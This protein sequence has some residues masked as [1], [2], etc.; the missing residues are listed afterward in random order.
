MTDEIESFELPWFNGLHQD[1]K[2]LHIITKNISVFVEVA[3]HHKDQ[4][5]GAII[6]YRNDNI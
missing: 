6:K 5:I 2:V 3:H 4:S 1:D